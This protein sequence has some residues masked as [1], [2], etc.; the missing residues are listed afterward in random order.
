MSP[1]MRLVLL[2]LVLFAVATW[3]PANPSW[4]RLVSAGL[5]AWAASMIAW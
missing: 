1:T 2:A 4:N 5:A 3:G